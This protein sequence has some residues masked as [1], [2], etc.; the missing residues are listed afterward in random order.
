MEH[1]EI[2][3]VPQ[4]SLLFLLLLPRHHFPPRPPPPFLLLPFSVAVDRIQ[5]GRRDL[6]SHLLTLPPSSFSL[7]R[8]VHFPPLA[9][10]SHNVASLSFAIPVVIYKFA[11][12]YCLNLAISVTGIEGRRKGIQ[13]S[14]SPPPP[15]P[16]FL[17]SPL[18]LRLFLLPH[19]L[20]FL[21]CLE[22]VLCFDLFAVKR[23]VFIGG[24]LSCM[25][26]FSVSWS[27][28]ADV[29]MLLS[30]RRRIFLG[31]VRGRQSKVQGVDGRNRCASSSTTPTSAT[32]SHAMRLVPH[33]FFSSS[34]FFSSF[35][36]PHLSFSHYLI[37]FY[38]LGPISN[39]IVRMLPH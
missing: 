18:P 9:A 26:L 17:P 28:L 15:L 7:L 1:P 21:P 19:P 39:R 30:C 34:F 37:S 32:P 22:W 16:L 29:Y 23:S 14:R 31:R 4:V 13:V 10:R 2:E 5:N 8:L 24:E 36:L 3:R 6:C 35:L 11:D 33:P 25:I 27:S 20:V 12:L 38:V